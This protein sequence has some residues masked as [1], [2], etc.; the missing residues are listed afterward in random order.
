MLVNTK[1]GS[2]KKS[3]TG[4]YVN[5]YSGIGTPFLDCPKCGALNDHSGSVTEWKLKSFIGKIIFVIRHVLSVL[6]YYSMGSF[7]LMILI[8]VL[9]DLPLFEDGNLE[10][11]IIVGAV[12]FGLLRFF[13]RLGKAIKSSNERMNDSEYVLRLKSLGLV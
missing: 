1:C 11:M 5:L 10:F 8:G 3:L 2:C 4:G 12:I 13:V 7:L 9:L 6:F